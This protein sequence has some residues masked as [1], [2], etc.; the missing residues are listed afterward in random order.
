MIR[1]LGFKGLKFRV[2]GYNPNNGESNGKRKRK[3]SCSILVKAASKTLQH[4]I[5][6]EVAKMMGDKLI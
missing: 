6:D 5:V 1:G 4:D 2:Y 3:V